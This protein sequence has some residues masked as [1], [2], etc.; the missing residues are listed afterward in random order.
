MII[1]VNFQFKQLERRSLKKSGLQRDSN[2]WP[3][4]FTTMIILH[5]HLQPQFKKMN[6]FHILHVFNIFV[7]IHGYFASFRDTKSTFSITDYNQERMIRERIPNFWFST[8]F[9]LSNY[10]KRYGLPFCSWV[11]SCTGKL[12]M[13][14]SPLVLFFCHIWRTT[15]CWDPEILLPW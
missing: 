14:F 11:Q 13:S 15:V 8:I 3:P 6:Y 7:S 1:A 5:S 10:G 12:Y 2:P 9:A 4:R